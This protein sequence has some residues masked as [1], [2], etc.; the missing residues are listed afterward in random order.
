MMLDGGD[1]PNWCDDL[2]VF[3]IWYRQ[4]TFEGKRWIPFAKGGEHNPQ[5]VITTGAK[6]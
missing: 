1:D 6:T 4:Q 3:Q 5:W 2:P